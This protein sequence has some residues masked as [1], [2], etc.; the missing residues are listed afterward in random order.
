MAETQTPR[1]ERGL[2]KLCVPHNAGKIAFASLSA[3][4][5]RYVDVGKQILDDNQQVPTG[6]Y[7]ASL[8]H[9]A[10]CS[11][12]VNKPEFVSVGDI[13]STRWLWV[14]N[15]NLWTSQGVYVFQDETATGR[16]QPLK[17]DEL[18]AK[19]KG[20]IELSSGGIRFGPDGKV[21]FA[22]AG[23][24]SKG[25]KT[26]E[27]FAQDGFII[28]SCGEEGAKKLGE[29]ST[30]FRNRPYVYALN[31]P[32]GQNEQRISAVYEYDDRFRFDG[33]DWDGNDDGCAFGVLK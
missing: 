27:E 25:Y 31:V 20:G 7:T 24:Y 5:G 15:R 4:P 2:T 16:T 8:L 9:S 30:K 22:P 1:I 32:E 19:L 13:M 6:D 33:D 12:A 18:E 28:A 10:Y 17:A 29:V 26:P 11:E 23:S 21:R 3:G 14:F